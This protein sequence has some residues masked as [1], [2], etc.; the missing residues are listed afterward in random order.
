[1]KDEH[2]I[3]RLESGPLT[4]LSEA[5]RERIEAHAEGCEDCRR[6]YA[7]AGLA[8]ELL[9][10]RVG[11]IE[12]TPFF[13]TRVMAAWRERQAAGDSWSLA[14]VW[15]TAGAL[16][17]SMALVV[18][19]LLTLTFVLP[20]SSNVG[21]GQPVAQASG[22]SAE[23]VVFGGERLDVNSAADGQAANAILYGD[24]EDR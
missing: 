5:E 6:A 16:V 14:R 20:G 23:D 12:P 21:S 13:H 15:R 8:D 19:V 7:A 10:R 4:R 17:S 9:R 1:M 3:E 2:I 11:T 24:D 22:Y 18:V